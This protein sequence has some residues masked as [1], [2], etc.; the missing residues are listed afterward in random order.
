M[1]KLIV[2]TIVLLT[3]WTAQGQI[4]DEEISASGTW[5]AEMMASH[6]VW[7]KPACVA[8]TENQ[9]AGA[10]L[11]VVAFYDQDTD[12]FLRPMVNVITPVGVSFLDMSLQIDGSSRTYQTIEVISAEGEMLAGR[13]LFDDQAELVQALR[14]R[15]RVTV[16]MTDTA[17]EVESFSFQLRG[18]MR[19]IDAQFEACALEINDLPDALPLLNELD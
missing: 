11:E 19:T 18:S 4:Q 13:T 6:D 1:N 5:A 12:S 14:L 3:T 16:A 7:G 8:Y 9:D 2:T 10:V 15:N 17:G